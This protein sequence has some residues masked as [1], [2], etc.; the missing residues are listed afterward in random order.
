[1]NA[2]SI[3]YGFCSLGD[4]TLEESLF[5]IGMNHLQTNQLLINTHRYQ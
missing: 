4:L 2:L 1:M 5:T 3:D